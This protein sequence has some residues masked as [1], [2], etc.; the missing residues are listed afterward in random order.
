MIGVRRGANPRLQLAGDSV[1]AADV[2]SIERL[3][4]AFPD[5]KFLTTLLAR[6]N[7]HALCVAARKFRNLHAFGCWWFMNNPSL[8]EETTRM[9]LELIGLSCTP[10]HS[11]CRVLDQLVYKWK[12]ARQMVGDVVAE[13]YVDLAAAG[14]EPTRAE[15]E[16]DV[17]DLF[18]GAF[19]T[20]T[21]RR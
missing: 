1:G 7:Q 17:R 10:Q 12:H 5:N 4:A 21:G 19:E 14:W 15:I 6:E 11:D 2:G 20:F 18:G 3:C 9:R 13:K 16:R 8:V